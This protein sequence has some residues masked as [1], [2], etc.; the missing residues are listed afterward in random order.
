MYIFYERSNV[1]SCDSTNQFRYRAVIKVRHFERHNSQ[2]F[3]YDVKLFF[4]CKKI[5]SKLKKINKMLVKYLC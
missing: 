2:V 1:M 4:L 5:L 3:C